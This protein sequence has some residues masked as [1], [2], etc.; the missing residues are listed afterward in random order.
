MHALKVPP[1]T[2][3]LILAHSDSLKA[4]NIGGAASHYLQITR[5]LQNTRKPQEEALDTLAKALWV[6]RILVT[7]VSRASF[8]FK[9][10]GGVGMP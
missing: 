10:W 8:V 1:S 6:L 5:V 9:N 7:P 3:V 4:E 2:V